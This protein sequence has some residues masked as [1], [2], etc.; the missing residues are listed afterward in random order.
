LLN[1]L[2]N[3]SV[4]V[5]VRSSLADNRM[6]EGI[7]QEVGEEFIHLQDYDG[8]SIFVKRSEIAFVREVEKT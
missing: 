2:L 8:Y 7:L 6:A 1:L 3:K 5:I 4:L